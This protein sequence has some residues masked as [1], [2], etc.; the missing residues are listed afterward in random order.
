M[1]DLLV[2]QSARGADVSAAARV[3]EATGQETLA[4]MRSE[5]GRARQSLRR[6]GRA[7][8]R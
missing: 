5:S 1:S 6:A 3:L 2:L 8:R 7:I 4:D